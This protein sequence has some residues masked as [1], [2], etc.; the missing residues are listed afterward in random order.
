MKRKTSVELL[1][2]LLVISIFA[3]C[4]TIR[5]NSSENNKTS[6]SV[7]LNVPYISQKRMGCSEASTAMVLEYYGYDASQE[8]VKEKIGGFFEELL[9][10]LKKYLPESHYASIKFKSLKKEVEEGNPVIIRI[11]APRGLHTVVVVGYEKNENII[12]IHDP[13]IAEYMRVSKE[14]LLN[15]W[16]S[17]NFNFPSRNYGWIGSRSFTNFWINMENGHLAIDPK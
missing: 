6:G 16:I 1:T 9:P 7:K 10:G 3:I 12:F 4:I 11:I 15:R 14:T 5:G 17:S 13:A 8:M 2:L